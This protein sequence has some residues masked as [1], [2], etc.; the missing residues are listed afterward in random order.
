MGIA[1]NII[2]K[3]TNWFRD[4]QQRECQKRT[5]QNGLELDTEIRVNY[6]R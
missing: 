5:L 2:N 4:L 1:A 3:I 6:E